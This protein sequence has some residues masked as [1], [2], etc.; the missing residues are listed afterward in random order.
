MTP[1]AS[2][3][4]KF[5]TAS[6]GLMETLRKQ[7]LLSTVPVFYMAQ[8]IS[9]E[10]EIRVTTR[11][12]G[13]LAAASYLR[14][15]QMAVESGPKRYCT[16]STTTMAVTAAIPSLMR[17]R[18]MGAEICTGRPELAAPVNAMT[19]TTRLS[20]AEQF[21]SYE[22]AHMGTGLRKFFTIFEAR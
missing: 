10:R 8:H 9:A 1:V 6:T 5:F 13:T 11:D 21:L 2:G 16:V 22:K 19:K 14:L 15:C 18:L 20:D 3:R 12:P 7:T 17:W 4:K